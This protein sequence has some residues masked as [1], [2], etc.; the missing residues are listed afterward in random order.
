MDEGHDADDDADKACEQRQDHEGTRGVQVGCVGRRGG[1]K[2][3]AAGLASG[4]N[5][6]QGR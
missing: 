5:A 1:S 6:G 4:L 3:N 2:V